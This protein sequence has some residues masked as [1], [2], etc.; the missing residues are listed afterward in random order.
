MQADRLEDI[1]AIGLEIGTDYVVWGSLTW[2]GQNF[3]LDAKLLSP[4][5]AENP[6][7]FSAE[8]EGVENLPA[9]LTVLVNDLSLKLFKREKIIEVRIKGNDRIE[10]DAIRRV[11]KIKPGDVVNPKDISDETKAVYKMGYFDDIRIQAQTVPQGKVITIV[12]TE[13]PTFRSILVDG[14][15]WV[16]DDDE[17]KE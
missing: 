14:N 10:A 17:I 16:Y 7:V 15:T 3:S 5:E 6:Q 11:L 1:R 4:T 2:I 12:V 8:G 9:T 13:K